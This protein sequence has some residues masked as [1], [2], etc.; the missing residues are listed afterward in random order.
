[1]KGGDSH[2]GNRVD[3]DRLLRS[4]EALASG[5]AGPLDSGGTA[6]D[7]D[8]GLRNGRDYVRI[9]AW[10]DHKKERYTMALFFWAL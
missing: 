9:I 2:A 1:M 6:I 4:F 10:D 8:E 3:I 5:M 7:C